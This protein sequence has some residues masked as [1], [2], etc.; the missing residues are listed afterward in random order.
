[1]S[2][3]YLSR[4]HQLIICI[5]TT[6]GWVY[7]LCEGCFCLLASGTRKPLLE[8]W[9]AN[10]EVPERWSHPVLTVGQDHRISQAPWMKAGWTSAVGNRH[11]PFED[12]GKRNSSFL[13]I[14]QRA[15]NSSLK[16]WVA[17]FWIL[18]GIL[19]SA[20]LLVLPKLWL[21]Q[22]LRFITFFFIKKKKENLG[23]SKQG[24]SIQGDTRVAKILQS[25][26]K[27]K[28]RTPPS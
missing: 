11:V 21:L 22:L 7:K 15:N 10:E 16:M 26:Y 8:K 4:E 2:A 3:V 12:P 17:Y 1:M 18:V 28:P 14:W 6:S 23:H 24:V 20:G 27:T 9:E 5:D 25:Y 19:A 13:G